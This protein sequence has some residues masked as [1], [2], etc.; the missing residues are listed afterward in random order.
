MNHLDMSIDFVFC[1]E[2][3]LYINEPIKMDST[4]AANNVLMLAIKAIC[5]PIKPFSRTN[6]VFRK[7]KIHF[8]FKQ[9]EHVRN[10]YN[11]TVYKFILA[12]CFI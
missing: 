2:K 10:L 1:A 4:K 6:R 12:L 11:L 7:Y 9:M 5:F 8:C 3:Y